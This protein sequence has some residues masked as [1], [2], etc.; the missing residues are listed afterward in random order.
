MERTAKL[1]INLL[2]N[3][4]SAVKESGEINEQWFIDFLDELNEISVRN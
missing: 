2:E 3:Y 4:Y 1:L